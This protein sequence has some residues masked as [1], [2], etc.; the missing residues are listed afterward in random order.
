ML[1]QK[2][3]QVPGFPAE[4]KTL[5]EHLIISHHG[6][7]E[8]GSPKMPMFP[9][10]LM[11]HYLDDLDSKMEAMR[12]HFQREPGAEWTT[13]NA[14]L[15]RPLLNSKNFLEKLQAGNG[16]APAV[17]PKAIEPEDARQDIVLESTKAAAA[18]E[19]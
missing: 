2:I 13:Y 11:L 19:K 7:Y 6:K 3:A 12:A 5:I 4:Y 15:A 17:Q 1:Q 9:E 16:P 14:S 8:F 18:K 10:A